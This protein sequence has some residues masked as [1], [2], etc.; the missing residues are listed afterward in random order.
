MAQIHSKIDGMSIEVIKLQ[1]D[2]SDP[3]FAT[4]Y[5]TAKT[6][7]REINKDAMLLSWYC[8]KTGE[9][10]PKVECSYKEKPA[11]LIF[12]EARGANLTIDIN[13]GEYIFIYLKL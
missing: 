10:S 8:K 12:A 1:T 13:D 7:A 5:T 6:K 11:W 2:D 4:A 9:F 3:D